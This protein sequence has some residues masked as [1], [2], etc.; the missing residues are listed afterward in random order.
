[1]AWVQCCV[2][3]CSTIVL[4][5]I[6]FSSA[7]W[8]FKKLT[9]GK[10][11]YK[12]TAETGVISARYQVA[13]SIW[14]LYL[15]TATSMYNFTKPGFLRQSTKVPKVEVICVNANPTM[16]RLD[17][18]NVV[19]GFPRDSPHVPPP[20][21]FASSLSLMAEVLAHPQYPLKPLASLIHMG[22]TIKLLKPIARDQKISK[23]L[24]SIKFEE[25]ERGTEL[26]S[27][28][29]LYS[30]PDFS[31]ATLLGQ[32]ISTLLRPKRRKDKK[33]EEKKEN[34]PPE[35]TGTYDLAVPANQGRLFA[36]S[37]QDYNPW[38]VSGL[39]AKLFGFK[40]AIAQ[41]YWSFSKSLALIGPAL[42]NYPLHIEVEWQK[43]LFLPSK[44][45]LR[46]SKIS[47]EHVHFE[48]WTKDGKHRHLVGFAKH[49]PAMKL[50]SYSQN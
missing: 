19:C 18:F 34:N 38:H 44:M 32:G 47:Q 48:M 6:L 49:D 9:L 7:I 41:G 2:Q 17:L 50:Q 30:S 14:Q 25:T 43:P 16:K 36:P 11:Q 40:H 28:I 24:I 31:D 22:Q 37:T 20:F 46:E 23:R 13:P 45:Q 5:F 27:M 15:R 21:H 3:C 8:L 29:E 10:V 35:V 4:G 39:L 42:P 1:M 26:H 12:K 33:D